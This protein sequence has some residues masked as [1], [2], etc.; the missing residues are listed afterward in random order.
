MRLKIYYRRFANA[1]SRPQSTIRTH[2]SIIIHVSDRWKFWILFFACIYQVQCKRIDI[3]AIVAASAEN[4][5]ENQCPF[6]VDLL[7]LGKRRLLINLFLSH[8]NGYIEVHSAHTYIIILVQI[9]AKCYELVS[10]R[11]NNPP[12]ANN[13]SHSPICIATEEWCFSLREY[14]RSK[15]KHREINEFHYDFQ[16]RRIRRFD[17]SRSS[18]I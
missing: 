3:G 17:C 12:S 2:N 8:S 14:T 11:S 4:A 16:D 18:D 7:T 1:D 5:R 9:I 13:I 15:I 10:Q 6:Y